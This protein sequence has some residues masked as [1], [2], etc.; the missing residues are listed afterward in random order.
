MN[1]DQWMTY[2]DDHVVVT[3]NTAD[4]TVA[5]LKSHVASIQSCLSDND[6]RSC[7]IFTEDTTLFIAA[8]LACVYTG[9]EVVL[10]ANTAP[11]F[12]AK[13]DV[14]GWI[15]DFPQALA[16][17]LL[18]LQMA[19]PRLLAK[20]STVSLFTSGS[21]G[22]PKRIKRRLSQLLLE[23]SMLEQ[24]WGQGLSFDRVG[25]T[26]SHQHIYG[27]L[28][29]ILWPLLRGTTIV[30]PIIPYESS[31]SQ[32]LKNDQTL[33]LVASPAFLKRVCNEHQ[34]HGKLCQVISAGGMLPSEQ[35]AQAANLLQASITQVYGSSETGG[36]ASRGSKG[37][38]QWL[39]GVASKVE[40]G[41]LWVQ[42]PYC[43]Q[44]GWHCTQDAIE[45]NGDGFEL[46]GRIDRIVKI[47]EFRVALSQVESALMHSDWI[48][49]AAVIKLSNNRQFL[50]AAVQLS[51]SGRQELDR[52]GEVH[53]KNQIKQDLL[54]HLD[55][56]AIPKR[57]RFIDEAL[58]NSQGKRSHEQLKAWLS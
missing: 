48:A 27:L 33:L 12:V 3:N 52:N 10:P 51:E 39:P 21:T 8:F 57:M 28:F 35:H 1:S 56:K 34:H 30:G 44:D 16:V 14:D 22:E 17:D 55:K 24:V 45:L 18:S 13:L 54:T 50:A 23:V 42:S 6:I 40:D 19:E 25:A 32:Y 20:D 2:G 4:I 46:L 41:V 47:E 9:V 37:Q 53:L 26:V 15:G 38:W 31:L 49:D 11:Q 5:Q 43:Y 29:K 58:E 7:A 36:M